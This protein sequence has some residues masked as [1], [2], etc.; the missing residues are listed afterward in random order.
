MV[1]MTSV[2][3]GDGNFCGR[4]EG[5]AELVFVGE[6]QHKIKDTAFTS[7]CENVHPQLFYAAFF[8]RLVLI[9]STGWS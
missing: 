1:I 4:L 3:D 2:R 9:A 6:S 7:H 5:A 8:A